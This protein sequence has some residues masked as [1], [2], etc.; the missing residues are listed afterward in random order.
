M[1]TF[2][3]GWIHFCALGRSSRLARNEW[4]ARGA[5]ALRVSSKP[6]QETRACFRSPLS[7]S[8]ARR[9]G[10][11]RSRNRCGSRCCCRSSC[12][13]RSSCWRRS[14][15]RRR[16]AI[17]PT[18]VQIIEDAG[19]STPYDHLTA[20]PDCRMVFS[21][22]GCIGGADGCPAITAGIVSAASVQKAAGAISSAPD[23]HLTSS[24]NRRVKR[25][26]DR[27]IGS[28]GDCPAICAGI[29]SPASV[30]KA[31]DS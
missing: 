24:P 6:F 14:G 16:R 22:N 26:P 9:W 31:A 7:G 18:S 30:K 10:R 29:V 25:S 28:A 15:S 17:S 11:P 21:S 4:L 23:D 20:S 12:R 5:L 2:F 13:R 8:W 19:P 27:R 1:R 3:G